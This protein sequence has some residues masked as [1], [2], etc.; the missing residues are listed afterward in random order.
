LKPAAS[1]SWRKVALD[2]M[3]GLAD[4]GALA[5]Q[6]RMIGDDKNA[7]RLERGEQFAIHL[8]AVD[9]HVGRVVVVEQEA[10]QVEVRHARWNRI[11]ERAR[12]R[13]SHSSSPALPAALETRPWRARRDRLDFA[14]TRSRSAPPPAPS[15]RW[16]SRRPR[17][18]RA[19]SC[20]DAVRQRRGSRG[21]RPPQSSRRSKNENAW[22]ALSLRV[23]AFHGSGD[24]SHVVEI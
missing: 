1:T 7:A 12:Y 15:V 14:Q 3:Q 9:L 18:Y 13:R 10:D 19:P 22:V 6:R 20:P 16:S 24:L 5:G 4:G 17:P 21:R 8:R 2:T 23:R 11:V